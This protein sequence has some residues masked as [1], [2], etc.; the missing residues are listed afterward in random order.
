MIQKPLLKDIEVQ[1]KLI[2]LLGW[3]A[4][5]KEGRNP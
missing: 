2:E 4:R 3:V 5:E 1:E